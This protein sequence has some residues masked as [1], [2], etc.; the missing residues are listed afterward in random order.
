MISKQEQEFRERIEHREEYNI[1]VGEH[2]WT[3]GFWVGC[4]RVGRDET[5]AEV[6]DTLDDA[7]YY[8]L[9]QAGYWRK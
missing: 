4:Y 2:D 8:L 7:V 5:L 1:T 6:F 9:T 3:L